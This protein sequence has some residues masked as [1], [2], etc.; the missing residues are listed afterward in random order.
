LDGGLVGGVAE[1]GEEVADFLLAGV[2]DRPCRGGVD[3]GGHPLTKLLE[4]AAQLL[5]QGVGGQS[6][7]GGHG[8]LR[9]NQA[10]R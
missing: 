7:F 4:A 6:G 8:L 3:S 2:D 1:V 10:N 9:W 5:Q